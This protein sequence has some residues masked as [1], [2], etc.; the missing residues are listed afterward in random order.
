L[1]NTPLSEVD[2]IVMHA[3][4]TIKGDA[5]EYR[6]IRKIFGENLPLLTTNKWKIGHTFGASGL[7]SI[8]LAVMMM[9]R[10]QFIS[11]PFAKAQPSGKRLQKILVNAVGFGGN[12]VSVLLSKP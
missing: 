10:Q 9:Q 4:G 6:A 3:P 12:A 5:T 11:V 2:A 7:L 1:Q 8:E